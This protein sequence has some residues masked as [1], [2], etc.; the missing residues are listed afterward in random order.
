MHISESDFIC[1][2]EIVKHIFD[3]FKEK[4]K[5]RVVLK[6]QLSANI[7]KCEEKDYEHEKKL[8]IM[9]N[10]NKDLKLV[11]KVVIDMCQIFDEVL[12]LRQPSLIYSMHLK[13]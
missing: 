11:K 13:E 6:Q 2:N 8:A 7:Q 1:E 3:M 9:K 5:Q 10:K 4:E 12:Q